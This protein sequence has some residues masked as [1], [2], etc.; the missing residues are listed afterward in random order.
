MKLVVSKPFQE[1]YQFKHRLLVLNSGRIGGK[2]YALADLVVY[3]SHTQKERDIV[4]CRNSYSDL[5]TS[6]YAQV[7]KSISGHNMSHLYTIKKDPLKII[8]RNGN[9]IYFE[10]IGGSDKDR[11]RGFVPEHKLSLIGY[12]ELQQV[13]D[14]ESLI[15]S[16]ASFRRYM[17]TEKGIIAHVFNPPPQNSHW[18]NLAW[19]RWKQDSD[20]LCIKT[21]YKDIMRFIN[22]MDLR[23]IL[24]MK[25]QDYDRYLN[26]YE[27]VP[28]G[29]FGSVYPQF[30]RDKHYVPY[31]KVIEQFG[32]TEGM[33]LD[34]RQKKIRFGQMIHAI[35]IGGDGAVNQDCTSFQPFA[36]M[37]D[38]HMIRLEVYH[39]DP[40]LNGQKSS[41][42]LIPSIQRWWDH[43]NR[44]YQITGN[45]IPIYWAIDYS[46]T[47]LIRMLRISFDNRHEIYAYTKKQSIIDMVGVMQSSLAS[48]SII[49]MNF[50]GYTEWTTNKFI[51]GDDPLVIALENL[52]WN[53]KQTGYESSVPNDDS[54]AATYGVNFIKRNPENIMTILSYNNS[55]KEYYD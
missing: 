14:E 40:K 26:V 19:K 8:H 6:T 44:N 38:G 24:K 28:G 25:I 3:L 49:V 42:E 10:G 29:G 48:N 17:D 20:Y 4:L 37:R 30:K 9:V 45:A 55:R 34:E 33:P 23:D 50:G 16:N 32:L 12:D 35:V 7:I 41:Y 2:S 1:I 5:E 36:L 22:D 11:T 27:G 47:E 51:K 31:M 43:L 39:Y 13:R 21:S 52:V 18:I 46:A 53:D 54:D 15:Q